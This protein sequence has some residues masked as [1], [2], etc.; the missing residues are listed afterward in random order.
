MH[1]DFSQAG[2]I[3]VSCK[4][5][6][7]HKQFLRYILRNDKNSKLLISHNDIKNLKDKKK[8]ISK[9]LTSLRNRSYFPP[10]NFA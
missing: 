5:F 10:H 7:Q 3:V 6:Y 1:A 9:E 2:F 4:I 8:N